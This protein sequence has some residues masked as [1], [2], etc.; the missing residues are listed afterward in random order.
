ML[1]LVL[2]VVLARQGGGLIFALA[3][4]HGSNGGSGW[5]H[6]PAGAVCLFVS[7]HAHARARLDDKSNHSLGLPSHAHAR[8]RL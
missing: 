1:A 8:A 4:A 6:T 3:T 2:V 7:P 5:A